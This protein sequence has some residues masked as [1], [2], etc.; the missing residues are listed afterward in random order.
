MAAPA[1]IQQYR[2]TFTVN[3]S[4]INS[5]P[6]GGKLLVNSY[7]KTPP[8]GPGAVLEIKAKI[9][10]PPSAKNASGFDYA[11][12]LRRQN[13]FATANALE[14]RQI[15]AIKLPFYLRAAYS[16]KDDIID[17]VYHYLPGEAARILVPMLV[18]DKSSLTSRDKR[19]FTDAGIMH[20]L[21][22]SGLNV[23]YFTALFV[24]IFRISGLTRRQ[25]YLLSIP[26]IFLFAVITGANPPVLR[27]SVMAAFV[28]LSMSLRRDPDI[29]H[30]IALSALIILIINPQSVFDASFQLS[31]AATLGIVSLYPRINRLFESS[32]Y[33]IRK[34][35]GSLFSVSL[36][37]QLA[38][39]PLIAY[40]FNR[41]QVIGLISNIVI[42]PLTGV[43]TISGMALYLLHFVPGP[44]AGL[45]S[46]IC[47]KTIFLMLSLGNFFASLDI[48]SFNIPS[49][50]IFQ[51]CLYYALLW[52]SFT[53]KKY[54]ILPA[55]ALISLS[56]SLAY[57]FSV[58]GPAFEGLRI[59]LL[60]AGPAVFAHIAEGNGENW[61][62]AMN[63]PQSIKRNEYYSDFL[64]RYFSKAG[65]N[66]I[67]GLI[68]GNGGETLGAQLKTE[69]LV[70]GDE[71]FSV[72]ASSA[73]FIRGESG[74]ALYM[75]YGAYKLIFLSRPD[76]PLWKK[77]APLFSG[78]AKKV[79]VLC[80]RQNP[81]VTNNIAGRI[82][83]ADIAIYSS[84]SG[85]TG[86][87]LSRGGNQTVNLSGTGALAFE[88]SDDIINIC[89]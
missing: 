32:P 56:A 84:K 42:V 35:P 23:A 27:A 4:K 72:A 65:I 30:S 68:A 73:Q 67:D 58:S 1:E 83:A 16:V 24:F 37:A 28:I 81:T 50:S 85:K 71:I 47:S 46:L 21:V 9:K 66:T 2:H 14:V 11:A 13:I 87:L 57:S 18:G 5:V 40:Y 77:T 61:V 8:P 52:A 62:F 26:F 82:G 53:F 45:A 22:V 15:G 88:I 34:L 89:P 78:S 55:A 59:N 75:E 86:T 10:K 63:N 80:G 76:K 49:P 51:I 17:T 60:E 29:I 70:G 6:A 20:I 48:S 64:Q 12:Y 79:V 7:L 74:S 44:L 39:L 33:L 54:Y 19:V 41:V 3:V 43:I 31:F 38:V 36:A 69:K 25:S